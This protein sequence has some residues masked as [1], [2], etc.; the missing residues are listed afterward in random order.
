MCRENLNIVIVL[1]WSFIFNLRSILLSLYTAFLLCCLVSDKYS[2]QF[3]NNVH[4][5]EVFLGGCL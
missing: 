5:V 1:F 4:L 2:S 3:L